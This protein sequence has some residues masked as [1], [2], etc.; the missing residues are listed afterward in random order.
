[1]KVI[2]SSKDLPRNNKSYVVQKYIESP[3]LI[4]ERKYNI[5][6]FALVTSVNPLHLYIYSNGLVR[7]TSTP[8]SI[9]DEDLDKLYIH[10]TN[11]VLNLDNPQRKT[12][13]AKDWSFTELIEQYKKEGI[14]WEPI[15]NDIKDITTKIEIM[16][17]PWFKDSPT[18]N[19]YNRYQW[20]SIDI[21]IDSNL[22]VWL[23]EQNYNS[24]LRMDCLNDYIVKGGATYEQLNIARYHLPSDIPKHLQKEIMDKTGMQEPLT[25]EPKLYVDD[26][27]EKDID[28]RAKI[29]SLTYNKDDLLN[30]L[31]PSEVRT[32]IRLEDE[33]ANAVEHE[34]LF[35][36]K[37][38]SKYLKYFKDIHYTNLLVDAWEQKYSN[39][40]DGI[41]LLQKLCNKR[42]HY[43]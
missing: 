39:S 41:D 13:W 16:S 10:V 12:Q 22:K 8:Y 5:R 17:E 36:S 38:S 2:K 6:A 42:Y 28:K 27:T 43:L 35:P 3:H 31:T 24:G 23:L 20:F 15:W 30:N 19:H 7:F 26:L 33:K 40:T 32:L 37:T 21:M 9:K 14:E 25:L 1:M 11:N 18:E 34:L 29:S 4:N